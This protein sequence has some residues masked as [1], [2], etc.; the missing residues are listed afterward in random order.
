MTKEALIESAVSGDEQALSVLLL[1]AASDVRRQL[2]RAVPVRWNGLISLDDVLQVTFT[3]VFLNIHRFDGEGERAFVAWVVSIARY[4]LRDLVRQMRAEKRGGRRPAVTGAD[5]ETALFDLLAGSITTPSRA[6]ARGELRSALHAAIG[7]LPEPHRSIIIA[8][9]LEARPIEQ[10]A[11]ELGRSAGSVYMLRSRALRWL[12]D[13][14]TGE[15]SIG[16]QTTA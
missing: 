3:D 12:R 2:S 8:I 4:N 16:S 14:L 15:L 6:L 7:D 11:G 5:S 1:A 13:R 10:V 9:D